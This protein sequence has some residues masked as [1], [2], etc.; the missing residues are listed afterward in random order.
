VALVAALLQVVAAPGPATAA[1]A[2]AACLLE[3]ADEAAAQR[4]AKICG[5]PVEILSER[6]EYAQV[7][8][9]V[10]GSRTLEQMVEPARV[11]Q[12]KSWVPVDTTLRVTADGVVPRATVLP[13]TFSK[14]G[15]QLVGRLRD[16]ERALAVTWPNKLPKP[17]LKGSTAIYR[18]VLP[19]VDLEVTAAATGFSEVLV[20]RSRAAAANPK[21]ATLKFGLKTTGVKVSAAAG[22]GLMAHDAKGAPVFAAPAPLMWDSSEAVESRRPAADAK[23]ADKAKPAP[24]E[25]DR[26]RQAVMPVRVTASSVMITPDKALLRGKRTKFP[27]Y[28]DPSVTGGLVNNEWTSVWSK[29]PTSSFWKNT[30]ALNN[31]S[32]YGSAGAGRTEDCDGCADH[33]IRSLFRMNTS[34]VKSTQI[35]EA[36]FRIEQ[37]HSWTCSP[38]SNAKVWLTGGFSSATTWNKQPTWN[39]N[40]T[41]QT[42][43]DRKVGAVHGCLGPGTAE[44]NVTSMVALGASK[45]WTSVSLGLR[46]I[47]ESTLKQWKRFNPATAKLAIKYNRAPNAPKAQKSDGKACAVGNARPYVL[48]ANPTLVATQSDPDSDQ[49]QLTTDF[50]W[51]P[52]G[53]SRSETNKVSQ[54]SGNPSVVSKAIPTGKLADGGTYV[55]QAKTTDG[56]LTAWSGTCEFTVDA[57]PPPDPSAV[58]ST[59]YLPNEPRGGVGIGGEFKISPPTVR[60]HEVVAYAWT[61]D[62]GVLLDSQTVPA[63]TT[64]YSGKI[65][66][67]KPSH[68]GITT[69]RVW[70][71]DHAGRYSANPKIYTFHVRAGSGPAAEWTFDEADGT[72]TATDISQHGNT[73]TLGGGATRTAGRGN[74]GRALALNG[75]SG[76]AATAGPVTY[77]HPDTNAVTTV[78]TDS[79]FTVTA[80]VRLTSASGVTGQRVAVAVNGSRTSALALG[81]SGT[82]NR[83]RFSMA[84][85]DA[86]NPAIAQVLSN[87]APTAGKWTHLAATYNASTKKLTLYVNG[88]AQTATATLTGGFHA[89]GGVAI[90]KRKWNGADDGLLSGAVDDVRLYSFVETAAKLAELALPLQPAVTMPDG[91]EAT[92]GGTVRVLFDAGGDTNVTKFKYSVGTTDLDQTVNATSAGGSYSFN[93]PV[94]TVTGQR[95]L[96]VVAVDDGNRVSPL[97]QIQFTVT[98]SAPLSGTVLDL[99]TSQLVTGATVRLQPG[100]RQVTTDAD[101]VFTFGSVNP[102]NYTVTATFNGRCG[103]AGSQPF[104]IDGQ[105]LTLQLYLQRAAD[106]QGHTCTER[107]ATFP[108]GSTVLP[109]TGDDAVTSIDLPYFFPYYGTSYRKVWVDTNGLLAFEDPNGSH[110]RAAGVPLVAAA[111]PNAV[112]AP[113]WDDLVVDSSAS[114]R[115]SV[116]G[117][118]AGQQVVVEWHNVHRKGNTAQRL[119]FTVTLAA[120]G[121]VST[122]YSGL[123]NTA[124]QGSNAVVGIE[125]P[126]GEDG[127]AYS[128]EEAVLANGKSVVFTRP[129][130]EGGFEVHNLS[131]TLTDAAGSPVAD[132]TVALDPSGL[133]TTTAANGGYSF[134]GVVADSYRITS[135]QAGGRCAAQVESQVELFADTVRDLRLGPDHGAMGY[136]C[137]VGASGY[138]VAD[139]ATWL[140][141]DDAETSVHLPFAMTVYGR[142]ADYATVSTNGWVGIGGAYLEPFWGD[143]YVDEQA[144]VRTK[145]LGTAPNRSFVVEWSNAAV[146]DSWERMS[147]ELILHEDGRVAYHYGN[148]W[149]DVQRGA[150]ATVGLEALSSRVADRFSSW[151]PLLT[152]NTSIT[153]TPAPAGAVTGVLTA[154]E[155]T[156]P[157]GGVTI[158][159]NPG[160]RSTTTGADG[161]YQFSGVAPG[162]YQLLAVQS[163]NRCLG[164]YATSTVYKTQG[165]AGIDL[166]LNADADHYY[167]CTVETKPYVAADTVQPWTGDDELWKVTAPF[168][169]KLYGET[170]TTPYVSSNGFVTL[171]PEGATATATT[172]IPSGAVDGTPNAAVYGF[173]GDWVI[174]GQAAMATKVSGAA[175]NRLWT[176]EWRN[177]AW[178]GNDGVRITFQVT[179]GENGSITLAYDGVDPANPIERGGEG[180]VGLENPSG[181]AGFQYLYAADLLDSGLSV[182]FVPRAPAQNVITGTVTCADEPVDG[183]T[184]TV[185]GLSVTTGYDGMYRIAGVPTKTWP[186]VATV[187]S[188]DCAGS[189]ER[190]MLVGATELVVDYDLDATP[191]GAGYLISEQQI[192]YTALSGTK[193]LSGHGVWQSVSLPFP[194]TVYG[195]TS[196][197][198]RVGSEGTLEFDG[199]YV[200]PFR[201]DWEADAQSSVLTAVRGSAPNQQFV[202]EWRDVRHHA[203]SNTRFTFQVIIDEAGGFSYL[204]PGN[205]GSFL[206]AGGTALIGL[207]SRTDQLAHLIYADRLA[208]LRPGYGLRIVPGNA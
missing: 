170:T 36:E 39:G 176:V 128:T 24:G 194:V 61:L 139:T 205:D 167:D 110:P 88:V 95:P 70:S 29:H 202:V 138:V 155:T 86:D 1:P 64:D 206:R 190:S 84:G 148:M 94:G 35:L 98:P 121:T 161:S 25:V 115:S 125:S 43:G 48:W 54:A 102:G 62:S 182:R 5:R 3:Q 189:T 27:V 114:V 68:D 165:D 8:A 152:P 104:E 31:G 21:L 193:L 22:G 78:R 187:P 97:T 33:I 46:A 100:G 18:E 143:L 93:L 9:N 200:F 144:E 17:Q 40:Y 74:T 53:G 149:N 28:I 108:T 157:L 123:D 107:T 50:Y 117:S 140:T 56:R 4:M 12:G 208:V 41:A 129:D 196:Q 81:Y 34:A 72:A 160:N 153:W 96:H 207:Q 197:S 7:F 51:W 63:S 49:Q 184:V 45:G 67:L 169:V 65:T 126:D 159:L 73:A 180:T 203:D 188:G 89:A 192:A 142:T 82:D 145:A 91:A 204:Y 136:S 2:A 44:F 124:E 178:H 13:M 30:T 141:G 69:L 122:N 42:R 154:A 130:V 112:V 183:A 151:E 127:F 135:K 83:W 174:D 162:V 58:T 118:G 199:A 146:L 133:T 85:T 52:R 57:T 26:K 105:G 71:K 150:N 10:D 137:S 201:G 172:P 120:D 19:D 173:W 181:T 90:G 119:S 116:T 92:A 11:R 59:D 179:F 47:D 87:A 134:F 79:S 164:Q 60:P 171:A 191:A 166:S 23:P 156:E 14:G 32:T 55:W 158:T 80:R 20:V 111:A 185:A 37:R 38:K 131:G 168:P 15:D 175:P 186:V 147:F 76:F 109:L 177:V 66:G 113:F 198:M 99:S 75:T 6:T 16:G 163:D 106:I 195:A 103:M 101:G 77:P 132:A